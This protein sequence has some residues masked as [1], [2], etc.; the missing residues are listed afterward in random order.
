MAFLHER[1]P[2][3]KLYVGA[4]SAFVI[5]V[6][7]K[8]FSDLQRAE[9]TLFAKYFDSD[10]I[11]LNERGVA[12][13]LMRIIRHLRQPARKVGAS[14]PQNKEA[15]PITVHLSRRSSGVTTGTL[16]GLPW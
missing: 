5:Y 13:M 4:V 7:R 8:P 16:C 11:Q 15:R 14:L 1:R 10:G 12:H 9:K 3:A 6:R 2:P